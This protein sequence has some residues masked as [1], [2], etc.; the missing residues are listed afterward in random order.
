MR[1]HTNQK[2]KKRRTRK[3][4]K[5]PG[6]KLLLAFTAVLFFSV[7]VLGNTYSWFTSDDTVVNHFEGLHLKAEITEEFSPELEWAPGAQVKKVVRVQNTGEIPAFVRVSLYEYLLTFKVDVTDQT[8]NGNLATVPA[9]VSPIV[10]DKDV[11]TWTPAANSGGTYEHQQNYFIADQAITP[12]QKTGQE[13]FQY[14]G[15]ER[16]AA[17]LKWLTLNF[18]ENVYTIKPANATIDYWLYRDGYFYYSKLLNPGETSAPVLNSVTLSASTP[19]KYKGALYRLVPVMDAHDATLP[20]LDAW[21]VG[22]TG[23]LYEMYEGHLSS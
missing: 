18:P 10:N 1:K 12:D 17:A 2:M 6:Y 13:M 19:N 11:T 7:M 16:E 5:A 3:I 14:Q 20:L 8:G 23:E 4:R 21:K 22:T 9:P 15:T